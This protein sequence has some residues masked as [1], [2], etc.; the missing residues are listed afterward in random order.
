[1]GQASSKYRRSLIAEAQGFDNSRSRESGA[2]WSSV[3]ILAGSEN[4]FGGRYDSW[5]PEG[6]HFAGSNLMGTASA[7]GLVA[8][9]RLYHASWIEMDLRQERWS[10]L[11]T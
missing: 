7:V 11:K 3:S 8:C 2:F 4:G 5:I 10:G 9:C 1:M 6:M